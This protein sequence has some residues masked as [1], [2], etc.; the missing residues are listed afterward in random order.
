[1]VESY[2]LDEF[3]IIKRHA[4]FHDVKSN[5]F[6][7]ATQGVLSS[8]LYVF[9][10]VARVIIFVNYFIFYSVLMLNRY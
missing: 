6:L 8:L 3:L 1:M 5:A 4:L 7:E 9:S 10:L 2:H